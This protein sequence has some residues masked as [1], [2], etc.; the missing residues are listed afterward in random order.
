[1][2]VS[3]GEH[4]YEH[5][6]MYKHICEYIHQNIMYMYIYIYMHTYIHIYHTPEIRPHLLW[7]NATTPPQALL[8]HY[9]AP[10]M[11]RGWLFSRKKKEKRRGGGIMDAC[12]SSGTPQ[13]CACNEERL[14]VFK[15]KGEKKGGGKNYG[16]VACACNVCKCTYASERCVHVRKW[17]VSCTE[18]CVNVVCLSN[19]LI[20]VVFLSNQLCAYTLCPCDVCTSELYVVQGEAHQSCVSI[21]TAHQCC[22]LVMCVRVSVCGARRSASVLYV[23]QFYAITLCPCDVCSSKL[24]VVQEEVRQSSVSIPSFY[25]GLLQKRPII[26]VFYRGLLKKRPIISVSITSARISSWVLCTYQV[27]CCVSIKSPRL[28]YSVCTPYIH[29]PLHHILLTRTHITRLL[30]VLVSVY[31]QVSCG[32]RRCACTACKPT[33]PLGRVRWGMGW[34]QFVGSLKR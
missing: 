23:Y 27:N 22:V 31:E 26:C 9:H 4:I 6:N 33:T 24:Y 12:S 21:K 5:L 19:Q 20:S 29:T 15:K 14:I 16:L 28:I 18:E 7:K 3:A 25:R 30:C 8:F 10:V 34:L 1:V 2:F 32:A 11:G 17:E 13:S